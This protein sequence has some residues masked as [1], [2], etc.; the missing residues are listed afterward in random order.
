MWPAKSLLVLNVA[1]HFEHLKSRLLPWRRMWI[2]KYSHSLNVFLHNLHLNGRSSECTD[3]CLSNLAL[4][5]N[6]LPHFK[7]LCCFS[8]SCVFLW[9]RS[10]L[11]QAKVFSH[12]S[13]P[14]RLFSDSGLCLF[15]CSFNTDL[16]AS[17]LPQMA[18]ETLCI[19]CTFFSCFP[20]VYL[21]LNFLSQK[22]HSNFRSSLCRD[23]CSWSRNLDVNAIS[24]TSHLNG[25]AMAIFSCTK[26][27]WY[28]S[29]DRNGKVFEHN[30]HLCLP[31][32][33]CRIRWDLRPLLLDN[34]MWHTGHTC[35]SRLSSWERRWILR[36]ISCLVAYGHTSHLNGLT[37]EWFSTCFS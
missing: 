17:C 29:F 37:S 36:C 24:H 5:W 31:P 16:F 22:L 25:F 27:M 9:L 19:R 3:R 6:A 7:H 10:P 26:A 18:H 15:K 33:V 30:E 14:K 13:Q 32:P 23:V 11:L 1:E 34:V 21:H 4:R 8:V 35:F 12:L 2:F 28:F 20:N